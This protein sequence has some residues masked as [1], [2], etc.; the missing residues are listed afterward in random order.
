M[1]ARVNFF[2]V[3]YIISLMSKITKEGFAELLPRVKQNE[4]KFMKAAT[5]AWSLREAARISGLSISTLH[6]MLY[7]FRRKGQFKF[8][9]D[10]KKTNLL[11]LAAIFPKLNIR[12]APPF[13]TTVRD[14][15][16]V[17]SY[18]LIVALVPPPLVRKYIDYFESEP[19]I[20]VE[21]YEY[22]RW[23]PLSPLSKYDPQTGAILPEFDFERVRRLYEY[24]VEKWDNGLKAPDVYDLV[25]LQGRMRNP[26]ARPLT[27][28]KE[29]R[30]KDPSL[31]EVSEQVL[32]YH[33]TRHVKAIWRGNTAL[34]FANMK[35]IPV[36]LLYF[37]GKDAPVFARI[38]CQLPG[39]FSAIIDVDKALVVGQFPCNYDE[40]IMRE[41]EGFD[42]EMP[43]GCFIQSS[44]DMRKVA[45]WFWKY[46]EGKKWVFKEEL[47][48][49]V[50]ASRAL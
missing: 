45:P 42:V 18:T 40:Y 36:R 22:L 32:S 6:R 3:F 28:Y 4:W 35:I 7:N 39:A 49:P 24:P 14:V 29:A 48:I 21:G 19:L 43:Y 23:S 27:I 44:T 11:M 33:F 9:I 25:L 10:L 47:C 16:N 46:V 41:A 37:E 38:L 30:K 12:R 5:K 17:G 20:V 15:Y 34:V 26:F 8:L 13:T 50:I 1:T 2:F 31:P